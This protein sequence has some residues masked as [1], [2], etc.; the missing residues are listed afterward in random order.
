[1][2]QIAYHHFHSF[3]SDPLGIDPITDLVKNKVHHLL[4]FLLKNA[5]KATIENAD[6]MLISIHNK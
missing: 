3:I 5:I 2:Q 4:A 1:M 6:A